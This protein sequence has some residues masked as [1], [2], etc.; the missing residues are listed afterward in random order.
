MRSEK[1]L[2][3]E[4]ANWSFTETAKMKKKKKKSQKDSARCDAPLQFIPLGIDLQCKVRRVQLRGKWLDLRRTRHRISN[5]KL[6]IRKLFFCPPRLNVE[7]LPSIH[8][9]VSDLVKGRF[10]G[11]KS[12]HQMFTLKEEILESKNIELK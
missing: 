8:E 3:K 12:T 4:S 6:P 1:S 11:G 7:V 2:K 9:N 5:F 10:C